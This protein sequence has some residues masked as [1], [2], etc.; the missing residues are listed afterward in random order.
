[1][2]KRTGGGRNKTQGNAAQV[3]IH[4]KS[5]NLNP[6]EIQDLYITEFLVDKDVTDIKDFQDVLIVCYEEGAEGV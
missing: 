1:M 2:V 4:L 3:L 5:R 6:G